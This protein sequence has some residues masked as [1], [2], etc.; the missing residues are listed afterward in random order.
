MWGNC[1]PP[2]PPYLYRPFPPLESGGNVYPPPPP[3][4]PG[5]TPLHV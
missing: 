5:F 3:I 1:I 2:P 4:P